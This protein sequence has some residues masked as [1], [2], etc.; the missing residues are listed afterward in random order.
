MLG[1]WCVICHVLPAARRVAWP[2]VVGRHQPHNWQAQ[3]APAPVP[4]LFQQGN[5]AFV[6]G[7]FRVL[8]G[9]AQYQGLHHEFHID[10]ATQIVFYIKQ[11]GVVGVSIQHFLA[12]GN[13][14]FFDVVPVAGQL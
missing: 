5:I 8:V 14:F 13:H 11:L 2:A 3:P 9:E 12:H 4:L 1:R 7:Q 6:L 10:H